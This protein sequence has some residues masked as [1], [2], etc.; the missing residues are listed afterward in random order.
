MSDT[1]AS[2][3]AE[4]ST[5][6]TEEENLSSLSKD[7]EVFR[8]SEA[9][10]ARSL[11]PDFDALY[12][13]SIQD[14]PA[15]W[16]EQA[17]NLEWFEPWT[18]AM[19]WQP[20]PPSLKWFLGAKC[21]ITVNALDRHA[22]SPT[23]R[24]KVAFFWV[25]EPDANGKVPERALTYCQLT[26]RVA[27]CAN[28]LKSLGVKT[29]D[30]VTLYMGLTPE[31][32]I[33]MLACAR[34]GAI[35]SVVYGGFSAP[36]LR[37]RIEDS[38]SKVVICTDIGYRRGKQINL[39]GIAEEALA[40]LDF[41]ENVL[42]YRRNPDTQLKEGFEH[43]FDTLLDQ[44]PQQCEPEQLDA[45]TP[46]FFL[47]T[48]GT[49]G[50]PKGVVHVHGGYAVGTS[51][52]HKLC[53]D[54]HDEDIYMCTADP[55]W[56]TGHS[57]VVYGPLINGATVLLA[58]GALDFPDPGRWWSI[59]EKYRVNIFYSTPTA[60]R[61]LMRS[62]EEY[63]AKYDLS[64]LKVLGTVGEPINPEAWLWYHKNIGKCQTPI[65]DTW[66]QTETGQFMI[67]TVPN[68]PAKPG[69]PGK[70]LPGIVADIVDKEGHPVEAGKGGFLVIK[71]QWPGMM[72]T[73]YK[74]AERYEKY[75]TLIP[76]L[77]AAGDVATKDEDGYFRVMGRA[78]DVMNVSGYRIGTAEVESA[79]VSHPAVAEAAVIGKPD[80]L[81]GESIKAFV[82][83]REGNEA[84]EDL[85]KSLKLHVREE[86]SPIA[87]P[88]EIE[89]AASLPK[90]RSG[91][92]MRRV[93]KA[94]EM[95]VEPG[96]ISTLED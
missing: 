67:A 68:Y 72:R 26:R 90:T 20:S 81:K 85:L 18:Q 16:E 7:S 14:P 30:R 3:P 47:Y 80:P 48:S 50:K 73:I 58:E 53:F 70:A 41:V 71:N 75:W 23:R 10:K 43:D 82:I 86:L 32:P 36:A 42:V 94:K 93:L 17:R 59:V 29:G 37:S 74:D 2:T 6:V 11:T 66:W 95:G 24:N 21:N 1:A 57:Y 44:Q 4:N 15:F 62:G 77:Y 46:L 8:P 5:A 9:T 19:E 22:K 84:S 87:V 49:T 45:E 61:A 51:Y 96:D 13:K 25:G 79:L 38:Q 65:V 64:S 63:P 31:L 39:K 56:I 83:L 12:E 92:I 78:D 76:G 35:H 69:S 89:F 52:T 33:A 91:K 27:Q 40:G 60:I 54:L 55:G 34:I 88:G 28:A